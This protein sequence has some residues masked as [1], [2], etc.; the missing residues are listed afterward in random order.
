MLV[1]MPQRCRVGLNRELYNKNEESWVINAKAAV[2]NEERIS[3]FL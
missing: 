2:P 3:V 1:S